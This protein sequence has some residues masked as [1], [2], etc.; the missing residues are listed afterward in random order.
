MKLTLIRHGI[1]EGNARHLY[2][3]ATDL[4]LLPEGEE[5]LREMMR[6]GDYPTAKHYCTSGMR[7]TEQTL[8]ILYGDMPHTQIPDLR[9][10]NFGTFEMRGYTDDLEHDADFQD[11]CGNAEENVCPGGESAR[12]MTDR[13]LR[14][15]TPIIERGEDTVCI[16]HGGVIARLM[17]HWFPDDSG[18]PYRFTPAAGRGYQIVFQ[19]TTPVSYQ[20]IG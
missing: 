13:A 8:Q 10:M 18:N 11:W 2:Y 17:M 16:T 5:T 4:P 14:A 12:Q 1:T 19:G 3:G 20:S 6:H 7:R 9:E 15:I